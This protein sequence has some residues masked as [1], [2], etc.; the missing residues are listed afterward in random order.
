[1]FSEY[2]V[3]VLQDKKRSGNPT[4]NSVGVVNTTVRLKVVKMVNFKLRV[5]Y[6]KKKRECNPIKCCFGFSPLI[7]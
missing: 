2:S 3:A 4:Y 6:H 1:M 7:Y 5:F